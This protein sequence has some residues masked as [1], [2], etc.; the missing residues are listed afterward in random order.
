MVLYHI[1]NLY[2]ELIGKH[3]FDL[4]KDELMQIKLLFPENRTIIENEPKKVTKG[5]DLDVI[6]NHLFL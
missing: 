4:K 2:V 5:L 1:L 6:Y 3:P